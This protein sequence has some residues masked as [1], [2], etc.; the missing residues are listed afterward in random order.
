M[1][2]FLALSAFHPEYM[3]QEVPV[4]LLFEKLDMAYPDKVIVHL[5]RRHKKWGETVTDLYRILGYPDG[6]AFLEAYG[7]RIDKS[8]KGGRPKK[9]PMEL[10]EEL[11]RRYPDGS[12][13]KS[14]AELKEANGD[15]APSI[16]S[17]EN[18]AQGLY[19]MS[20]AQ[21]LRRIGLLK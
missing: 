20:L 10:I 6:D 21:Y 9:D 1:F 19:G 5:N 18:K 13:F 11:R 16:K 8:D 4:N 3:G 12:D 15:I 14:V 7:Y 2:L 17:L